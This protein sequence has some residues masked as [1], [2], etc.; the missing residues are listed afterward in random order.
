M[1]ED[2]LRCHP[3]V[4]FLKKCVAFC[5]RKKIRSIK[6][7]HPEEKMLNKAIS[8]QE[9]LVSL[10]PQSCLMRKIDLANLYAKSNHG[11]AEAEQIY[12]KLLESDLDPADKQLLYN[13]FASYLYF[14]QNDSCRS[15]E[16]HMRAAEIPIQ[17]NFRQNSI[18]NLEK[19][20]DKKWHQMRREVEEFLRNLPEPEV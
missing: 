6:S 13:K 16:Y 12:Q 1:A 3:D 5:Y 10:Y 15:V 14:V 2:A 19:I 20:R 17:C 8:L 9:E 7:S 11:Q 4:R 18:T